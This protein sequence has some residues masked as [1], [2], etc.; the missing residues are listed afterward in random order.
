MHAWHFTGV[1]G[2]VLIMDIPDETYDVVLDKALLDSLLCGSQ[3]VHDMR[4][5]LNEIER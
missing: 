3:P 4:R 1:K 2:N 5:A